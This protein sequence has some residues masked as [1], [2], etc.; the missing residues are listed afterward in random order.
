MSDDASA[1]LG[2]PL[3]RAGQA[4]KEMSH[5]EALTL[6]DLLAQP[7]VVAT[8]IDTPPL[9]PDPGD[10]WIVGTAPSGAWAGHGG[11]LAGWTAGGWRHVAPRE[12]MSAWSAADGAFARFSGG[13]WQLGAVRGDRLV[14]AGDAV[15]GPRG[16]AIA[17]PSGG[18]TV[19]AEARSAIGALLAALRTHG[20]IAP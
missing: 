12:G 10:C 17:A 5:N 3:L 8:G 18:A 15:V 7:A 13:A 1:R 14:L 11:A 9:A 6:L 4:Q 19:D 20:L 2:L 16:A